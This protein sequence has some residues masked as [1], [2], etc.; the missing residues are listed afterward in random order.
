MTPFLSHG[1]IAGGV[2]CTPDLD[3]AIADYHGRLGLVVVETG[4]LDPELAASWGTPKSAHARMATLQPESGAHCF[5]RLIEAPVPADF[6]PTRSF[7]WAAYEITVQNVFSLPE[8]LSGSGFDVVGTPKALKGMPYFVPMQVTGRG[9]EMLYL[10]EVLEDM[11]G[12]DLP[13]AQSPT[14]H[15]FIA[16]LATPDRTESLRWYED[17]LGLEAAGSFTLAYSMINAAFSLPSD[18]QTTISMVQNGRLP[19][20]EVDDY[21]PQAVTRPGDPLRLPPGNAMITLAVDDLD[22]VSA[23]FIAPPAPRDGPVYGGRRAAT[24]RGYAGELI[25]LLEL[26][27]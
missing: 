5:I 11:P 12:C 10:N 25:E 19:I 16:I 23:E 21:P 26:G 27:S 7:G 22:R 6:M 18:Y 2:V 14:D 8:S 20:I 15:I 3:A 1:R 24:V 9:R 17:A 4:V 13:K